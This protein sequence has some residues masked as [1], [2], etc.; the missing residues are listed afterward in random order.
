MGRQNLV[1]EQVS[2]LT[3]TERVSVQIPSKRVVSSSNEPSN[4][5]IENYESSVV[6]V[7]T[8]TIGGFS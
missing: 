6:G 2:D 4:V 8:H 5:D 1:Q 3:W 7:H